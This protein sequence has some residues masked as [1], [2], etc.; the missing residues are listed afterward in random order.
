MEAEIQVKV[1]IFE[2][3]LFIFARNQGK[4]S[5]QKK[6]GVLEEQVEAPNVYV[7]E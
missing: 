3:V 7:N 4:T 6:G 1:D 2:V 5:V